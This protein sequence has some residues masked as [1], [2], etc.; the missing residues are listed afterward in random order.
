MADWTG[1]SGNPKPSPLGEG[2]SLRTIQDSLCAN[3]YAA[4]S[5]YFPRSC[6]QVH[7]PTADP[8]AS[9]FL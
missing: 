2:R 6:S 1:L 3:L 9:R 5:A 4:E 7:D 8:Q